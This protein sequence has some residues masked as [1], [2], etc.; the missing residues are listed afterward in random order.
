MFH[1]L[2]VR[3]G[4]WNYLWNYFYVFFSA[5]NP[6]QTGYQK[7][8]SCPRINIYRSNVREGSTYT[9]I[10]SRNLLGGRSFAV[11]LPPVLSPFF[12]NFISK[13][14]FKTSLASFFLSRCLPPVLFVRIFSLR[15]FYRHSLFLRVPP[16]RPRLTPF[17]LRYRLCRL[18]ISSGSNCGKLQQA[19]LQTH[20]TEFMWTRDGVWAA[21]KKLIMLTWYFERNFWYCLMHRVVWINHI[22]HIINSRKMWQRNITY[23]LTISNL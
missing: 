18:K 4:H 19:R 10:C 22:T 3:R 2:H 7:R 6:S 14:L 21:R 16:I 20:S 17:P 8:R 15:L 12:L 11:L 5:A 13:L 23:S 9:I 1:I